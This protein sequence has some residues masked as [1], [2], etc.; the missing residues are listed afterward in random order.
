MSSCCYFRALFSQA[1]WL[2]LL[3][4]WPCVK[5]ISLTAEKTPGKYLAYNLN[6]KTVDMA[7]PVSQPGCPIWFAEPG[8]G[9]SPAEPCHGLPAP[10]PPVGPGCTPLAAQQASYQYPSFKEAPLQISSTFI[11]VFPSDEKVKHLLH[12]SVKVVSCQGGRR[13]QAEGGTMGRPRW[14]QRT[15]RIIANHHLS[16]TQ[17][18]LNF[19]SGLF[20][21]MI[22]GD[23]E[24]PSAEEECEGFPIDWLP[25]LL[26]PVLHFITSGGT[27]GDKERERKSWGNPTHIIL[28]LKLWIFI[29]EL[30]SP[31]LKN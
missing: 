9:G 14:D 5:N 18:G 21:P 31:F 3:Q 16:H 19:F 10:T 23:K 11:A 12:A 25:Q 1:P 27:E 17:A 22:K 26:S 28:S 15:C 13:S 20:L 30:H 4:W 8:H 29:V 6:H 24:F 7:H 2:T